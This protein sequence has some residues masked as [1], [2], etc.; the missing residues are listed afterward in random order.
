VRALCRLEWVEALDTLCAALED[1][2]ADLAVRQKCAEALGEIGN[3]GALPAL[4]TVAKA[5]PSDELT[6]FV[7]GAIASVRG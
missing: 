4:E 5:H 7:Y 3:A 2:S 6:A 1:E